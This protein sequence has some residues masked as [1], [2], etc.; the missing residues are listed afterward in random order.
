MKIEGKGKSVFARVLVSGPPGSG[1]TT[2]VDAMFARNVAAVDLDLLGQHA[3]CY[4][5]GVLTP[6]HIV[7][8]HT[9]RATAEMAGTDIMVFAGMCANMFDQYVTLR[10]VR[11]WELELE[12]TT[13]GGT[14]DVND[15][16]HTRVRQ[17]P[18]AR[19]PNWT[20]KIW[21]TYDPAVIDS[22]FTPD[23]H[24]PF[25]RSLRTRCMIR[26]ALKERPPKDWIVVDTTEL[27]PC[28]VAAQVMAC[29]HGCG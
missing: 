17:P 15:I 10:P 13:P 3:L 8:T 2:L 11:D 18:I 26:S 6:H 20:H 27:M 1:K 14:I 19:L 23:R 29:I 21:L 22:R 7:P 25:G 5:H 4:D 9:V 24:N 12:E 16:A 28:Q